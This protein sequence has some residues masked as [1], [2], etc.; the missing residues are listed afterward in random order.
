[1]V[2]N[3]FHKRDKRTGEP[4]YLVAVHEHG[5]TVHDT[6]TAPPYVMTIPDPHGTR[7]FPGLCACRVHPPAMGSHIGVPGPRST[8]FV[9]PQ[10]CP[11]L[12]HTCQMDT[13]FI[14]ND[15]S[16]G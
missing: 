15:S 8:R 13:F 1:M 11:P 3:D 14:F 9:C 5:T 2:K 7:I 12:L 6:A 10:T 16:K 4:S